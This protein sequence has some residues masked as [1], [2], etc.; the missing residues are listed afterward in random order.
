MKVRQATVALIEWSAVH[1]AYRVRFRV[2]FYRRGDQW[3]AVQTSPP[4]DVQCTRWLLKSVE[5][6]TPD[7]PPWQVGERIQLTLDP[8]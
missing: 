1:A 8:Y 4:C 2:L 5:V 6:V 3:S 7:P